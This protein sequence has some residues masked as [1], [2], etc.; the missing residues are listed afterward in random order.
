MNSAARE[1]QL[2]LLILT[3]LAGVWGVLGWKDLAHQARAGFDTDGNNKVTRVLA[4]SSAEAAGLNAGDYITHYDGTPLA[5]ASTIARQPRKKAG[6]IRRV[7]VEREGKPLNLRIAYRPLSDH[8]LSLSRASL[9]I[10]YCFLLLPFVA[11]FRQPGEATRVLVVAGTGLSLAFMSGP[12]MTD[13]S[14]RSMTLAISSLY[15]LFGL[16]ALLQFLLVF[17]HRRPWLERKLGKKL[18]YFPAFALWLLI[19]YRA[20]FTPLATG[21]LNTLTKFTA[22]IVVGGY[23]LV[24]LFLVLR[25]Y[26]RTD[27][28]ERKALALNG[29]LLGTLAGLIPVTIAQMI[30]AFSPLAVLPGHNYY[31]VTLALIP[32]TWARSA[33]RARAF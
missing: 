5:D 16:A 21:G 30:T 22:G 28:A 24:C 15:V 20:V 6:D 18:I 10:G 32:L 3:L 11:W 26:S 13:F 8:E 17:P 31:F 12:Y 7:S 29:M 2:V 27:R 9:I 25:N 23:A 1:G 14:M 19:A 33:S 4:G